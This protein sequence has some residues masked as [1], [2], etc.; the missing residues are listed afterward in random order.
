[1]PRHTSKRLL[2]K[3]E[4]KRR[5]PIAL[6]DDSFIDSHLKP[7]KVDSKNSILELSDN[8]LKV[9]G[10]IDASA[11][12]VDGASVQTGTGGGAT[13][14]NELSDVTYSSGDLTITS[15]DRII[16]GALAIDSSDDITLDAAGGDIHFHN[17]ATSF[18]KVDL[19]S[20]GKFRIIG[21]TDYKIEI[22][23]QGIGDIGIDSGDD[24]TISADDNITIDAADSL[25]LDSDG[26][27]IMKK[28]GT[29]YSVANSAYAGMILG[30]RMI[31]ED[32]G[33]SSYTLTTSYVV[34]DSAMTVRFIAPPSGAVEV[35]VQVYFD[36]SS[37]RVC[38]FGLSDN[39]TYNSIG[40]SYEQATNMID[41]SDQHA[42]QHFWTIT[43]LT[44]GDT[45]N[46]WLGAS[47]N[48]GYIRW[49]GTGSGRYCDFIMKVTALPTATSD[50]AEYD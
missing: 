34:P 4:P 16:S 47:A 15:L 28:D 24:I 39:A 17:N 37:G 6:G 33:H 14:L 38:N 9:R 35:M 45:Y 36:G 20:A 23:S 1:M 22:V 50:F 10:T 2:T 11:I 8:E 25:T 46:Y 41:E 32:A 43:G 3:Y 49:G 19:A 42:H 5:N 21:T 31:G 29:E 30:Y 7:I 12:T 27:Y 40:N 48:S 26:T 44:A 18:G 13:E